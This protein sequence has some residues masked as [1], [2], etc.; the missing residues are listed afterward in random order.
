MYVRGLSLFVCRTR[1][2]HVAL[3]CT[4][5]VGRVHGTDAIHRHKAARSIRGGRH[6]MRLNEAPV[7]VQVGQRHALRHK[8]GRLPG[9]RTSY[10]TTYTPLNH[11]CVHPYTP[12]SRGYS[13]ECLQ[14]PGVLC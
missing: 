2:W 13:P 10:V 6:D 12:F 4:P 1:A 7:D 8:E 14:T 3:E 11:A 5:F 9:P